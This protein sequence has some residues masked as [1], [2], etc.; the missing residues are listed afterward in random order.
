[1]STPRSGVKTQR[2]IEV[3]AF[4]RYYL[5]HHIIPTATLINGLLLHASSRPNS[6]NGRYSKLRIQLFRGVWPCEG[7]TEKWWV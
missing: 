2:M 7:G 3:E 6:I 1:M 5:E 4:I